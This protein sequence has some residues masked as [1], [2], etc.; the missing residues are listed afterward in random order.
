MIIDDIPIR[1]KKN[2]GSY[3]SLNFNRFLRSGYYVRKKIERNFDR[4][5]RNVVCECEFLPPE[6]PFAL[7][8]T[9]Y[10]ACGQR[11]DI[12]NIGA[13]LDKLVSDALV[14]IGIIADDS[15]QYIKCVTVIDGGVDKKRPRATLEIQHYDGE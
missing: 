13:V 5:F 11:A 3:Q 10:R 6:P 1:V 7:T 12:G 8:Y 4:A 2:A 15:T 14:R 9:V